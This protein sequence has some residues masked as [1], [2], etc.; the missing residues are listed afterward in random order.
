ITSDASSTVSGSY[1]GTLGT[2]ETIQVSLDG[3]TWV[4][5]TADTTASTFTADVTLSD[6]SQTLSVRTVDTAGNATAG[7]GHAYT[8]DTAAP[9][10][11]ATITAIA[12]DTGTSGSD[13]ITSEDRKSVVEGKSGTLGTGETSQVSLDGRTR[14][15]ATAG[16]RASALTADE[17]L[18]DGS[19]TLSVRTVDTAGN[20]TAGSGHAYT[21]DTAAPTAVATITAIADDTGTSGSDFITS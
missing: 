10:A 21:L 9:T 17:P 3:T 12:D 8:L 11:V 18:S 1:T 6:G 16:D 13:F 5:A 15:E 20:A 2:G 19:Q 14:V 4:D 7:S